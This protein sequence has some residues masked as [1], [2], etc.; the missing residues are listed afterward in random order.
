MLHERLPLVW[1]TYGLV[2]PGTTDGQG[3]R[4]RKSKPIPS[5]LGREDD[6]RALDLMRGTL[7]LVAQLLSGR[8]LR[9]LPLCEIVPAMGWLEEQ[10]LAPEPGNRFRR[11]LGKNKGN[12]QRQRRACGVVL[13]LK[14][15]T[16]ELTIR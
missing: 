1:A 12:R 14:P 8:R 2:P 3:I 16:G 13:H 6:R 9:L 5:V 7:Q 10:V 11:R 4:A 15:T